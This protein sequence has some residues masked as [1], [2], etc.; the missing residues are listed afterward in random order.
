MT[1]GI[2]TLRPAAAF[3]M[4]LFT[5]LVGT[6]RA[7]GPALPLVQRYQL[8]NGLTVL[9]YPNPE[10]PSVFGAVA[11]KVGSKHDPDEAT[12]MAHY[13]EHM[14]FKGTTQLGTIDWNHEK[15][16]IDSIFML[17]EQLGKTSDPDDR[18]GIQQQINGVSVRAGKFAVPNE[19][20]NL[21]KSIGGTGLNAFTSPD[22]TVYHN[23]FPAH[24]MEKWLELY[25]HRFGNPVFRGFQSE[26]EVVYEEYNMGSD[27]FVTQVFQEFQKAM[28][29]THPYGYKT[30]IGTV[31][32]LKNPSL[33]KMYD[34][35]TQ[36]YVAANM[37]LVLAGNF[38]PDEAREMIQRRFSGLPQGLAT[39]QRM[40]AEA[41][42]SGRVKVEKALSPIKLGILGYRTVP[43]G[44]EDYLA[45][46]VVYRLLNNEAGSGLLDALTTNNSLLA[47]MLTPL[48]YHDLGGAAVIFIPK[49][50]GQKLEEAEKLVLDQIAKL[51]AGELEPWKL[52]SAKR[53]LELELAKEL[54]N[55]EETALSLLE[56]EVMGIDPL[57]V[58]E[59]SEALALM[60][61]DHIAAIAK[62]YFGHDYLAFYS[63]QN[64]RTQKEK[65]TKPGY[66]P[67]VPQGDTTS[68]YARMFGRMETGKP[69]P[70]FVDPMVD[71]QYLPLPEGHSFY[72]TENPVNEI[73]SLRLVYGIGDE[74]NPLLDIASQAI[75]LAG[76]GEYAAGAF[77]EQLDQLNCSYQVWSGDTELTIL[78][79]GDEAHLTEA[80]ELLGKL[81]HK[82]QLDE[83][84]LRTLRQGLWIERRIKRRQPDALADALAAY[85]RYGPASTYL[86]RPSAKSIKRMD[87]PSL[88]KPIMDA[89]SYT[90]SA[91]FVGRTPHDLLVPMLYDQGLLH[92]TPLPAT[93]PGSTKAIVR[94]KA[95]VYTYHK[96]S[97]RQSKVYFSSNDFDITHD[98]F[99]SVQAFNLYFGGDF[100]GLVL[101]EI[102]EYRALAYSAGASVYLPSHPNEKAVFMGYVG[103]QSD[104]TN[105]AV[106]VMH[107]LIRNMPPKRNRMKMIREYLINTTAIDRPDMRGLS[108]EIEEWQAWGMGEDPRRALLESFEQM[109]FSEIEGFYLNHLKHTVVSIALVGDLRKVDMDDLAQYGEVHRLKRKDFMP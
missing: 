103:T 72:H 86:Q 4:A 85:L 27:V 65:I 75:S 34:F 52:E 92:L 29:P 107:G 96:R 36:H 35:F 19:F 49:V 84:Q 58:F 3:F 77:K 76:G 59:R 28:F 20:S 6:L 40:G 63:T 21:I 26:L 87:G 44:H 68:E 31:E 69:S 99:A 79:E 10:A 56:A 97:A 22:M 18:A 41:P 74:T 73:F 88:C 42:F 51:Q 32:H 12:G 13:Q 93:E 109:R 67:A 98:Q 47:A 14:L 48:P 30:A 66:K 8:D 7:Q 50:A 95:Q 82:P 102:R 64:L 108:R 43:K 38:N 60:D 55:N 101:Q 57:R 16:L 25:A 83:K 37:V 104:K 78:L 15:P 94:S 45:L 89:L 90:A 23:S 106:Q 24:Q 80:L 11:V 70:L 1:Q 2:F 81:L 9:L 54:E 46:Q 61:M 39:T 17:Y 33:N 62:R 5:A 71:V 100:S 91:H 105:E 53:S